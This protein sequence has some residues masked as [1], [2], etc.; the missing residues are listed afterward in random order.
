VQSSGVQAALIFS[1]LLKTPGC[2]VGGSPLLHLICLPSCMQSL[3][4]IQ[5]CP[6]NIASI[7]YALLLLRRSCRMVVAQL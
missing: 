1:Y 4:A 3:Y 6:K 5:Q 7:C 2:P